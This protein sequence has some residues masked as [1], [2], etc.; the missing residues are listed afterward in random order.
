MSKD[1]TDSSNLQQDAENNLNNYS[2]ERCPHDGDNPY[3]IANRDIIRNPNLS[4]SS[5]WLLIYMLTFDR[6]WKFSKSYI[7]K[8]QNIKK[9]ALNTMFKELIIE[10]HIKEEKYKIKGLVR[11]KYLVSELPK[12]KNISTKAVLPQSFSPQSFEPTVVESA[13]KN[14]KEEK[15]EQ[16]EKN[17]TPISPKQGTRFVIAEKRKKWSYGHQGP[18]QCGYSQAFE[19]RYVVVSGSIEE[20]HYYMRKDP[21]WE[22][23]DNDIF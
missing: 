19:D 23:I 3:V 22:N 18:S 7:M 4:P 15:K 6:S 16:K 12:F 9:D 21:F 10:G 11:V 14:N 2:I 20:E 1:T 17:I 8:N 5:R 13:P